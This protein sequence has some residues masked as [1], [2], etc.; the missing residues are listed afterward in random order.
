MAFTALSSSFRGCRAVCGPSVNVEITVQV[1]DEL[2]SGNFK[3]GKNRVAKIEHFVDTGQN[4][5]YGVH[6]LDGSVIEIPVSGSA[7]ETPAGSSMNVAMALRH[8]GENVGVF[9]PTGP[10][11][12]AA[13][14]RLSLERAGVNLALFNG[15]KN[16]PRTLTV[17]EP[18]GGSTLFMVKPPYTLPE[19]VL[20]EL[21]S[22]NPTV[23]V[24]TGVKV[25]DL[26]VVAPMFLKKL[27]RYRALTPGPDLIGH[28]PSRLTLLALCACT[29]VLQVNEEEALRF[30]GSS[31]SEVQARHVG[32]LQQLTQAAMVV[33]TLSS[34][35]AFFYDS[36]RPRE[37]VFQP[38][39]GPAVDSSG[40]GDAHLSGLVWGMF[41]RDRPSYPRNALYLARCVAGLKCQH[42]GPWSGLPTRQELESFL[43]D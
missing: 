20:A 31:D 10:G 9:A 29:D 3:R 40:A 8:W 21:C 7:K 22:C 37:V 5:F 1:A 2:P 38:G 35:G 6:L 16:T 39:S 41:L 11:E 32:E 18:G 30:L 43:L 24:A 23:V 17:R 28:E 42:V 34:R 36:N 13:S 14:I 26:P 15:M 25:L 12:G 27:G 33:V 4:V 19:G